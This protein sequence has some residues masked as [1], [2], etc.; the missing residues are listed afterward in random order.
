MWIKG[1]TCSLLVRIQAGEATVENMEMS[2]KIKTRIFYDQAI[3]LPGIYLR[4]IKEK[5]CEPL[6][7]LWHDQ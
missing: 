4:K 3:L 5:I 7:S 1:K 6:C 2:Q